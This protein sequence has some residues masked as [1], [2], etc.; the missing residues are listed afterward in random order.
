[1]TSGTVATADGVDD[2]HVA[3]HP[4]RMGTTDRAV[5][6]HPVQIRVADDDRVRLQLL[7]KPEQHCDRPSRFSTSV[8]LQ[9][10][11]RRGLRVVDGSVHE[12]LGPSTARPQPWEL[13][14]DRSAF[15]RFGFARVKRVSDRE[16]RAV[17]LSELS[18]CFDSVRGGR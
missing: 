9:G 4:T 11:T 5:K 17:D 16:P 13:S 7:D 1:M 15:Q 2:H 14:L 18:G 3:V 12:R 6:S 8:N 10:A